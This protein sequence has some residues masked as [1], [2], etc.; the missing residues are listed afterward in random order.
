MRI[1]TAGI[2]TETNTFAPWPTG[3][4]GFEEGGLFRGNASRA[5]EGENNLV[6]RLYKELACADGHD[7]VE[8]VFTTAQPSGPTLQSVWEGLRDEIVDSVRAGGS[9]DVILLLLHGAMVATGC[10]DCE[11]DLVARLR[12]VCGPDTVI[13]VEL[14]PHCHLSQALVDASDVVILMKEYPHIDCIE[15]AREL[16]ALCTGKA[17]GQID[18]VS[19][20]FDCRMIGFYPTTSEPMAGLLRQLR[21]AE[22]QP[23]VLSV[24]FVHGFPWGDTADTG[25]KMLVV[26]DGDKARARRVA[27]ELG[28]LIYA[29]REVLLPRMPGIEDALDM[30]A[31]TAGRVVLADTADNAGGGAPSDNV[32]LLRAMLAHGVRDAALGAIWDPMSAQACA[33]AGVGARFAL[34]LG[35][36]CGEASGSP[37]DVMATVRAVREQHDQHG[38]GSARQPMGLSVWLECDGIDVVVNS[39]RTQVFA[40]DA[41]TGLGIELNDKRLIVVKSSHHFHALFAPIADRIISVATPGAIQMNFAGIDYRK[42]H[43][44]NFFPRE[45][46]PLA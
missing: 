37:L 6:A 21:E 15:R 5:G 44:L 26:A 19:A 30:A 4:R 13:G 18:P 7:F 32:S 24:S 40:P 23:G 41:F 22:H 16:Y 2:S 25:S 12:K 38:L 36:K 28:R 46:D 29:Q 34:R 11:A 3:L 14:D 35:G 1:F 20:L 42:R 45:H 9:F 43:D 10:D 17:L 8:G 27:E 39:I 31:A 33:E